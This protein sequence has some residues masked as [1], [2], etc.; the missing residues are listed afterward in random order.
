MFS[1]SYSEN[2]FHSHTFSPGS[3]CKI[4]LTTRI[5]FIRSITTVVISVTMP[6]SRY[7]SMSVLATEVSYK[8]SIMTITLH[9][10]QFINACLGTRQ[11]IVS[12]Y[13]HPQKKLREGNGFTQYHGEGRTPPPPPSIEGKHPLPSVGRHPLSVGVHPPPHAHT[14]QKRSTGGQYASYWNAYLFMFC[15]ACTK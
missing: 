6:T 14:P 8:Y 5:R 9:L 2:C 7:T 1:L 4:V 11:T 13:Y 10:Y 12:I 15:K 3:V